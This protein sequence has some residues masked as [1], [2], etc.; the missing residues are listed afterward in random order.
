MDRYLIINADDY[1]MCLSANQAVEHLF[2]E[3]FIT[4]ATL[5]TPCPWAE[6]AINRAKRNKKMRV[7]LHLTLNSEYKVYKWGPVCRTKVVESL[8]DE[9]GYFFNNVEGF[10]NKAKE[11]DVDAEIRAQLDFM[12]KRGYRP[13]H[14]D[15]HMG[16]LYGLEGRSYLKEVFTLCT[17]NGFNFRMPRNT[18]TFGTIPE[19]IKNKVPEIV[20][21]ADSLGIG[22]LDNLCSHPYGLT[23]NDS[24]DTV[25]DYY[26]NLMRNAKP[27]ITEIFLHPAKES[28]E[29]KAICGSWQKRVWEYKLMLDDDVI[30]TIE[31]EGIKLVG[32]T[33]APFKKKPYNM[34]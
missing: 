18:E 28:E 8:V 16:S 10:L 11:E 12:V 33:N 7:G 34:M 4:S 22:I 3:G 25:K 1:G 24:Y 21:E 5:M 2:D 31:T 32:W 13:T 30:K 6:D 9:N 27:G 29:L 23:Q 17:E 20:E 14:V 26:L 19:D 15:N